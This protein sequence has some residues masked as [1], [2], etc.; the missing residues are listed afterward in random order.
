[1]PIDVSV[2]IPT[3]RRPGTLA[4][5][6]SSVLAQ[7]GP[8]LE[9]LVI[10]DCPDGSAAETVARVADPRVRYLRNPHPSG[11][12]P[13]QVRN[14]GWP[15]AKG[16]LIHFLDDDDIVPAGHYAH[17]QA[18]LASDQGVGMAF[19]R[20][21]LFG[22]LESKVRD[23]SKLFA[24]GAR[25]AARTRR[26][27]SR[28]TLTARLLFEPLM[29]VGGAA[30]V[31]RRCVE[32]LGG[33]E[34]SLEIMEDLD[35][36]IRVIRQFGGRYVDR[37]ALRY[38]IAPSLMHRPGIEAAIVDSYARIYRDYCARQGQI[39]FYLLQALARTVLRVI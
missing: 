23:E 20:M 31:R 33:F 24:D 21:E 36:F 17:M 3:F 10:D 22:E 30:I 26:F 35:F 38:R 29:F 28:W 2:V 7:R 8:R 34:A 12:R 11:G 37:V 5:A 32:A 14:L 27:G 16:E 6:L 13:A 19:G 25:R 9:A 18:V 39:E 15:I 1:M 4:E